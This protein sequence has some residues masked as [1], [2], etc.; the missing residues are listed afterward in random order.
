[1]RMLSNRERTLF[2][3]SFERTPACVISFQPDVH[4]SSLLVDDFAAG[5][6]GLTY[7]MG[8]FQETAGTLDPTPPHNFFAFAI[9]IGPP[10]TAAPALP[11]TGMT[12]LLNTTFGMS[13]LSLSVLGVT[14]IFMRGLLH[15]LTSSSEDLQAIRDLDARL[16]RLEDQLRLRPLNRRR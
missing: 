16:S 3:E 15:L 13:V 5:S 8:Q 12:M 1:M 14:F 7:V 4:S 2:S 11:N 9:F 6:G 10:P